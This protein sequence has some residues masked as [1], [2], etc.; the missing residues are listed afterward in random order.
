VQALVEQRSND[1]EPP[2]PIQL[3]RDKGWQLK[4]GIQ[5]EPVGQNTS[6]QVVL[7]PSNLPSQLLG[8]VIE[9]TPN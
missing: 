1:H 8:L 6:P 3:S 2:T 9:H 4:P 7:I 5:Q